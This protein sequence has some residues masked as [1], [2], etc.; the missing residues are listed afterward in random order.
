MVGPPPRIPARVT[1][2]GPRSPGRSPTQ[3]A[4]AD[5]LGC[6]RHRY[7]GNG[8]CPRPRLWK[9]AGPGARRVV[10]TRCVGWPER[11]GTGGSP[12]G[13]TAALRRGAWHGK[14]EP[15]TQSVSKW[16]AGVAFSQKTF[17]RVPAG[18][19]SHP[20]ARVLSGPGAW[21]ARPWAARFA[22]GAVRS[23]C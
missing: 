12:R 16:P 11:C 9:Q 3:G 7:R 15:E 13:P 23:A 21:P 8:R 20:R 1:E 22:E 2:P 10:E 6:C 17:R 5:L 14:A 18:W 4:L 19:P